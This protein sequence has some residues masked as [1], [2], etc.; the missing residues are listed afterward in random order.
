VIAD[1]GIARSFCLLPSSFML[2]EITSSVAV[3]STAKPTEK[4]VPAIGNRWPYCQPGLAAESFQLTE[5]GDG[6]VMSGFCSMIGSFLLP[7]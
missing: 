5:T 7:A 2:I 3:L 6:M 4:T 1:Q